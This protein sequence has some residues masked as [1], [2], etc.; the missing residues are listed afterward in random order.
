MDETERTETRAES[1]RK[2]RT[3]RPEGKLWNGK[4]VRESQ[5]KKKKS[6]EY[7]Q[8]EDTYVYNSENIRTEKIEIR[9]RERETRKGE[10]KK[11]VN[12]IRF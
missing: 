7:E 2:S 1:K 8:S 5:I 12:R 10:N 9:K 11:K 3:W 6:I 4:S